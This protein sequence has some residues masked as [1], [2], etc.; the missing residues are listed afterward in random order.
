M[1]VLSGL[2]IALSIVSLGTVGLT[3]FAFYIRAK[4]EHPQREQGLA[5]LVL[6]L[7]SAEDAR[8]EQ[9]ADN[10]NMSKSDVLR[11]ALALFS[12]VAEVGSTQR[13]I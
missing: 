5:S 2:I 4:C 1:S 7:S 6:N 8:L 12:A 10:G 3:L 11:K 13:G 9:L